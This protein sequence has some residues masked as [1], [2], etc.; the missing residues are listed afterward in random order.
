MTRDGKYVFVANTGSRT[1]SRLIG[2]GGNVFVDNPVAANVVTGGAPADIDA[3]SGVLGVI[4]HSPGQ[5]HLSLFTYNG[6]GELVASAAPINLGV[7]DANGVAIL[8]PRAAERSR[9]S[10]DEGCALD[11]PDGDRAD[12]HVDAGVGRPRRLQHSRSGRPSSDIWGIPPICSCS[13]EQLRCSASR[14]SPVQAF[15]AFKE[16][17][18]AGCRST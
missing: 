16:W 14:P 9:E 15:H 10:D 2:T 1:L 17:A 18:F 12:G 4:D 5:S 7:P 13:S 3:S 11:W 8:S 6:F